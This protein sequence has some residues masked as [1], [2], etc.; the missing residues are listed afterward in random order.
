MSMKALTKEQMIRNVVIFAIVADLAGWIGLL[1]D[2]FGK[3]HGMQWLG[4][5]IWIVIPMSIGFLLRDA[6][7]DGWRDSGVGFNFRKSWQWYV[8]AVLLLPVVGTVLYVL[9]AVIDPELLPACSV[10]GAIAFIPTVLFWFA[11]LFVKN[12]FEEFAWRGYLTPRFA[13]IGLRPITNHMLT[14]LVWGLWHLPYWLFFIDVAPY[15]GLSTPEFIIFW[16]ITMMMI[17][18][19][20]GELRIVSGTVWP[21]V[22]LHALANAVSITLLTNGFVASHGGLGAMLSQSSDGVV[23]AG[24]FMLAGLMIYCYRMKNIK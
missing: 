9:T 14:G 19:T 11:A 8:F 10:A 18:I 7:G 23:H 6:A 3:A 21:A 2:E 13:A 12:I 4:M 1:F 24:L 15:T 16:I 22:I 20:Y 5:L 17:A